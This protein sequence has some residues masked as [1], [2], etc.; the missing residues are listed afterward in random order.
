MPAGQDDSK[1]EIM[2]WYDLF[3]EKVF[4][5]LEQEQDE[6]YHRKL[7]AACQTKANRK[8]SKG[9]TGIKSTIGLKKA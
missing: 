9:M 6:R 8:N 4:I 7:T 2:S 3:L 5:Y 1:F